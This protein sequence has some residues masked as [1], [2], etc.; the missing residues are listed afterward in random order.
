[1]AD[2]IK[3]LEPIELYQDLLTAKNNVQIL[4]D[5]PD[6]LADMKG[7]AYWA[8]RVERLRELVKI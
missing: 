7:L 4:L 8:Q 5:S 3:Q 6:S 1:M 2:E